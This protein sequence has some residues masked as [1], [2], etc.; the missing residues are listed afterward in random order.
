[1]DGRS[2]DSGRHAISK[3]VDGGL[4]WREVPILQGQEPDQTEDAVGLAVDPG[5]ADVVWLD[6]D[7]CFIFHTMN[8]YDDANGNVVL[9]ACRYPE[10]WLDGPGTFDRFPQLERYTLDLSKKTVSHET[11]RVLCRSMGP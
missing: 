1:M 4:T 8:A 3:S 5:N 2:D 6:V 7:T 11:T 10:L 9:E